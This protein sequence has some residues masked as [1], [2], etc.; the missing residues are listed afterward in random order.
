M[1]SSFTGFL[2]F[3]SFFADGADCCVVI[4]APLTCTICRHAD[5]LIFGNKSHAFKINAEVSSSTT[6]DARAIRHGEKMRIMMRKVC[7]ETGKTEQQ[8]DRLW[9]TKQT[10]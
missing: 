2:P 9:Y 4:S 3:F 1:A 5:C 7:R 10:K 6:S 8:Q